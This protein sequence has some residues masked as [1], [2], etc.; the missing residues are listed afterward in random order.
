[1]LD[2][3]SHF[4]NGLD[5]IL[6]ILYMEYVFLDIQIDIFGLFFHLNILVNWKTFWSRY[7][8][9]LQYLQ[10]RLHLFSRFF[11]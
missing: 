11:C 1:M 7:S 6:K 2:F 8:D 5:G 4:N 10:F 3:L 9:F